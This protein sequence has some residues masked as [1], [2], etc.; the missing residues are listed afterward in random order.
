VCLQNTQ[1]TWVIFP[2]LWVLEI[3]NFA[4]SSN[5]INLRIALLSPADAV[6]PARLFTRRRPSA[7][8]WLLGRQRI[9]AVGA[10]TGGPVDLRS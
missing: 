4:T 2:P 8:L 10:D 1:K 3:L 5:C 6:G 7:R 9:H